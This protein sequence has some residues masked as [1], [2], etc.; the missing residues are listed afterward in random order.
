MCVRVCVCVC[1][2]VRAC[3]CVCLYESERDRERE[4]E[5]ERKIE[6]E[7][8]SERERETDKQKERKSNIAEDAICTGLMDVCN[9]KKS[10][11]TQQYLIWYIAGALQKLVKSIVQKKILGHEP[12]WAPL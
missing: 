4:R 7:S 5:K 9:E 3:V 6:I 12:S 2:C 10:N 8:E 11:A 1:V